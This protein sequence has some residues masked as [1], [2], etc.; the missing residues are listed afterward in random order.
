M[1]AIPGRKERRRSVMLTFIVT[2]LACIVFPPVILAVL[3]YLLL[4]VFGGIVGLFLG[5]MVFE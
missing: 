4:G 2:L 5:F 1:G 3:G